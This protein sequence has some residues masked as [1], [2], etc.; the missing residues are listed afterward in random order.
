ML[1]ITCKQ[2]VRWSCDPNC[3]IRNQS[4]ITSSS[5]P[6]PLCCQSQLWKWLGWTLGLH[7]HSGWCQISG[8]SNVCIKASML[9]SSQFYFDYHSCYLN[10][11]HNI[12]LPSCPCQ[13]RQ[14][15]LPV[16]TCLSSSG[17]TSHS[18]MWTRRPLPPPMSLCSKY[19]CQSLDQRH[20]CIWCKWGSSQQVFKGMSYN[21]D[22]LVWEWGM[23]GIP[24][25]KSG[26]EWRR[27]VCIL[28]TF[29][30]HNALY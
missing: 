21:D 6:S 18:R 30:S 7:R 8:I 19:I 20:E 24:N 28:A 1:D 11:T 17:S 16:L 22:G 23:C 5:Q 27:Y 10:I 9:W 2:M 25:D 3:H 29:F 12:D 4:V 13:A 14:S 15:T 26:H